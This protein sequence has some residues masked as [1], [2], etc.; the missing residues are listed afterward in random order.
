MY[1]FTSVDDNNLQ[2]HMPEAY[3][4]VDG[5][6]FSV[7]HDG[8]DRHSCHRLTPHN[9]DTAKRYNCHCAIA[10]GATDRATAATGAPASTTTATRATASTTT[11]TRA[12]ASTTTATGASASA[13]ISPLP[14]YDVKIQEQWRNCPNNNIMDMLCLIQLTILIVFKVYVVRL[15]ILIIELY[16]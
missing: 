13:T 9:K 3:L 1:P 14:R 2:G 12:T 7:P 8:R 4:R 6:V 5:L 15:T 11:A 10:T 16:L